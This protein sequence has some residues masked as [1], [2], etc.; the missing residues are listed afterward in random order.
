MWDCRPRIRGFSPPCGDKISS[1]RIQ[2]V[3]NSHPQF[4]IPFPFP[5]SL[6]WAE[7]QRRRI[8]E[9][10]LVAVLLSP[11]Q[12]MPVRPGR[13]V[14]QSL[15]QSGYLLR[16]FIDIDRS[17]IDVVTASRTSKLEKYWKVE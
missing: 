14:W 13:E 16:V 7:I 6:P 3:E 17:P 2:Q 9:E 1:C 10:E 8:S 5:L 12:V 11:G 4:K 15:L